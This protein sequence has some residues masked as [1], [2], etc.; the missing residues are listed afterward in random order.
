VTA[1]LDALTVADK[2]EAW[3]DCGFEVVGEEC[4]VGEVRIC[5]APPMG[6]RVGNPRE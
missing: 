3:R 6:S 1:S 5:F 2:P 4:V